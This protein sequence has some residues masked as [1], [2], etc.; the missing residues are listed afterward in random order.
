M[1]YAIESNSSKYVLQKI[2]GE[3]AT[4]KCYL[5]QKISDNKKNGMKLAE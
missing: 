1:T 4:C 2:L 5:G 3:G